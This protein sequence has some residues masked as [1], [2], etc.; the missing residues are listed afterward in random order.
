MSI[1]SS[2]SN[3]LA[4]KIFDRGYCSNGMKN[5]LFNATGLDPKS[6]IL[7]LLETHKSLKSIA[8]TV[9]V[10]RTQIYQLLNY[11]DIPRPD[12]SQSKFMKEWY[13]EQTQDRINE[14]T[15]AANDATRGSKHS[16]ERK[17]R[18]AIN[19]Q[20]RPKPT[21]NEL[22]AITVLKN[23]KF[24][25]VSEYAVDIYNV[26]IAIPSHHI[27]IEIQGGQWHNSDQHRERDKRKKKTLENLGWTVFYIWGN[28]SQIR[29]GTLDLVPTLQELIKNPQP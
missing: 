15:A 8:K 12:Y 10:D 9:D 16:R 7:H 18:S 27:A 17:I 11:F 20:S 13:S 1:T 3:K 21:K 5:K 29:T 22:A 28:A 6:A 14:I 19:R 23:H 2:K 25:I 24:D 4:P 26:D